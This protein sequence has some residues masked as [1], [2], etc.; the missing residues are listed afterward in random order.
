MPLSLPDYDTL[1]QQIV[2]FFRNRFPQKDDHDESFIGKTARAV[3]MA[4]FGLLR[5][6]KLVDDD[7]VPSASTSSDGLRTWAFAF[8]VPADTE[9]D[10]GPK[11][12]SLATGGQGYCTGTLGT[13]FPDGALLTAPDGQTSIQLTGAVTIVGNPPGAGQVLGDFVAVTAGSAGNLPTGSVLTW[14]EPPSG[15]D[16][17]VTLTAP[18]RGALDGETDDS[19]LQRTFDRMQQPPKGGAAADYRSWAESVAGVFRAYVYP[20][21]AGMDTVQ[22]VI[23]TAGSGMARMP[24]DAV[25]SAVD[26]YVAAQRPVTVEGYATLV[27]RTVVPG[28]ALRLRVTPSPKSAFNWS[29]AGTSY[30][31]AAYSPPSSTPATLTLSPAPP[32]DLIAAVSKAAAGLSAGFPLVQVIASGAGTSVM[33]LL[34]SCTAII[35]SVLNV[36]GGPAAGVINVGDA[37]FAGGPVVT[38]IAIAALA[39]VDSLGPSRQ[40]GLVDANDYWDDTCSIARL[41]Q[42]ALD[43]KDAKGVPLCRNVV[44]SGVTIDGFAQDREATDATGDAPELLY[45]RSI[46]VTD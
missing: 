21:R 15:A 14:E 33:P 35:G 23:T 8:G 22:V 37:V 25:R 1:W 11:G 17:T 2:V 10:Y 20:L 42:L 19:L 13:T 28:M 34:L 9:G 5:A 46:A 45:V 41:I 40:S 38:P 4:I 3:G 24:S 44:T 26:D 27:P 6:V 16:S 18:L 36:Q 32:A 12:P 30:S 31:V 7:A 39:Y 29:S 43:A